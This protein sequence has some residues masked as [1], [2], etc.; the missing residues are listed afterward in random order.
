[1]WLVYKNN[2]IRRQKYDKNKPEFNESIL[3]MM[4]R[5]L[6]KKKYENSVSTSFAFA[7]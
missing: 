1:M 3:V 6:L 5:L 7:L 2:L 4:H